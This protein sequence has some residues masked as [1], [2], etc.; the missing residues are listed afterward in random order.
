MREAAPLWFGDGTFDV[1]P[2][3]FFQLYTIHCKIGNNIYFL[4]SNKTQA[5][6]RRML[7]ALRDILIPNAAPELILLDFEKAAQNAFHY[8]FPNANISGC[9]FH[10]C[11]SLLRK[12]KELGLKIRIQNDPKFSML[13]KSLAA[14]SFVPTDEVVNIFEILIDAFPQDNDVDVDAIRQLLF[15]FESAYIRNRELAGRIREPRFP[16]VKW[17][18]FEHVVECLP[19]TTNC[20]EGFH[21]ALKS[22]FLCKHPT[23]WVLFNR[24]RRDMAIHRLTLQKPLVENNERRRSKYEDIERRL[25]LRA[26]NFFWKIINSNTFDLL[27]TFKCQFSDLSIYFSTL[28]LFCYILRS[29]NINTLL[30]I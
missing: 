5:T 10:L 14:L 18:H 11:Q 24:L 29:R 9:F 26:R 22:M 15:Y 27:S 12:A 2:L 8:V 6:Y 7:E 4:L 30:I 19:K 21:N 28:F 25:S 23:V 3:C 20:V 1:A 17:N 16:P 13:V